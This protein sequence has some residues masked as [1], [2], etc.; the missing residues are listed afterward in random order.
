M[1]YPPRLLVSVLVRQQ[2]WDRHHSAHRLLLLLLLLWWW[3]PPRVG[4]SL[5]TPHGANDIVAVA[6]AVVPSAG[7][8]AA[9]AALQHPQRRSRPWL[10]SP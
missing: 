7:T 4:S 10:P 2:G 9:S 6:V 8:V 3:W 5:P 1:Q